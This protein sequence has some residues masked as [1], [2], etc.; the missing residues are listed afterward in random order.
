MRSPSSPSALGSCHRLIFSSEVL[1]LVAPHSLLW[2]C[3]ITCSSKV[4]SVTASVRITSSIKSP[5]NLSRRPMITEHWPWA[6]H[7]TGKVVPGDRRTDRLQGWG[8]QRKHTGRSVRH[9]GERSS[10]SRCVYGILRSLWALACLQGG[11]LAWSV[12]TAGNTEISPQT[13]GPLGAS[14]EK[15]VKESSSHLMNWRS[16]IVMIS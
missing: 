2:L 10:R 13:T 1:N 8:I 6:S 11:S 15:A 9:F 7:Y 14:E 5:D 16:K 12:P 3:Y 4:C